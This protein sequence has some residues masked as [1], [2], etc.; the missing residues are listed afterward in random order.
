M[1]CSLL[2][3]L[4]RDG[5]VHLLGFRVRLGLQRDDMG[6]DRLSLALE[7]PQF[8]LVILLAQRGRCAFLRLL[9][10][11]G[12]AGQHAIAAEILDYARQRL[13]R[14][15]GL[16]PKAFRTLPDRDI[17]VERAPI[18][19]QDGAPGAE[20]NGPPAD[21]SRPGVISINLK[22]PSELPT[23]RIP[24]LLHHEGDPG[25]HLQGAV[26]RETRGAKAPL[27]KQFAQYSA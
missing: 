16:L 10:D 15:Q 11:A 14:I 20:Y 22:T 26:F 9:R 17:L 13:A 21:G 19:I 12:A 1:R 25:H 2:Q 6:F 3:S 7:Q 18:A 27:Y 23:W 4:L 5:E 8:A 24:T